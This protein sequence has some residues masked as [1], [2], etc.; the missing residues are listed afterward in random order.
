MSKISIGLRG[1]RF[2]EEEVFTEDGELRPL[3]ELSEDTRKRLVRLSDIADSI[4]DACW[5]IHGD[6]NIAECNPAEAVYGEPVAEVVVC[7]DHEDD[8]IYWFREEGGDRYAGDQEFRD[9]FHEWFLDGGRAPEGYEGIQHVET[10]P[11][12]L[13]EPPEVDDEAR[14]EQWEA[15]ERKSMRDE[16][17]DL[18]QEYPGSDD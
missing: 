3:E 14:R 18:S 13:P 17:L 4:C 5:L 9:A 10:E 6:E 11:E 7:G 16:E 8:L 1:W 2:D 15:T 12:D